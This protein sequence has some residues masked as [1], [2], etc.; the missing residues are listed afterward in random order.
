MSRDHFFLPWNASKARLREAENARRNRLEIVKALS[1]GTVSRRELFKWGLITGAGLIAPIQGLSP[2]VKSAYA[3]DGGGI[4]TGAPPSPGTVGLDFTQ[5]LLRFEVLPRSPYGS[6][7][8][9]PTVEANTTLTYSVDPLLGGGIGPVEG[10]PPGPDWGHQRWD[11]F[12]PEVAYEVTQAGAQANTN[13]YGG[14]GYIPFKFHPSLPVQ[15]PN[16]MWTFNGT[17][18]PKLILARYGEPILCRHHNNLPAD[19]KQ[20]GGFGRHTITT[21]LHNGH[22]GAENDGFTGAFF[23]PG[24][25]YDYHWPMILAGHDSINVNATDPHAASPDDSFGAVANSKVPGDWHETMSTHWFHDHMF[26][27]TSHNTY[28]GNAA[29]FNIYSALDRGNESINDGVNLQLPSGTAK[30]WGNLDY[31]VN[32][33]LSDKAWDSAGQLYF[34]IFNT[35]GFLGDAMTVNFAYKPYFE[36]EARKYRFRI[37]NASVSRFF[38]IALSDS[39]PMIQIGNDGNLL[40]Q[41][42][43]LTQ[44]DEQGI[45]ERYDIVIDFSRYTA[46]QK[47]WMVNLTEH[48]NG[49]G[50]SRD[51]TVAQA[52]AGKSSDPGVGEFLE[53]RV[54]PMKASTDPS[55]VPATLIPNPDLSKIPVARERTFAFK[56]GGSDSNPWSIRTDNGEDLDADFG[57]VS[58]APK[59]GTREVWTLINDGGNW[60]H[61]IHIHFEEGQILS[62]SGGDGNSRGGVPA[63]ERGR[64]DVYR[65]GRDGT[66][67]ITMQFREFAGMFMEHCHNT[68]HEDHAMLLRYEVG[69]G[70]VPMPTP[71]PTPQGVKYISTTVLKGAF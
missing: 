71:S 60:D 70:L 7:N 59:Q 22:H 14:S 19:V 27:F 18:P 45:A 32:L 41:P 66:V 23:F 31:D 5:P 58:A 56:D 9:A 10:R 51:L 2:F 16:T 62:R 63:W 4:P 37:L 35:D 39:S 28:K 24:Q 65:L 61:P 26:S 20:N 64:K 52:L 55:K 44:L 6:L 69:T 53:F 3:D 8:P 57:R 30:S 43:T 47:V 50:P 17:L 67:T 12:A 40:P 25:F 48:Q 46:G 29:M 36:V 15:G 42:V 33:M 54:I 11:Q 38:K 21:H 34:D 68:V 49:A 13:P 1:H